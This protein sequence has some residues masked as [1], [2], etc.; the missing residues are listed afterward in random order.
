MTT[1]RRGQ[2]PALVAS[3]VVLVV[4]GAAL[5]GPWHVRSHPFNG[6]F[7]GALDLPSLPAQQPLPTQTQAPAASGHDPFLS[8]YVVIGAIVGTIL[9]VLVTRWLARVIRDHRPQVGADEA[10]AGTETGVDRMATLPALAEG[11]Q[12][13]RLALGQDVPPGDAV[14]AAWVALE[15]AAQR[16]GVSRDPAQTPTEFTV[17]VLDETRADPAATRSLLELYLRARF[18]E[19][20]LTA[21]D[22]TAAGAYLETLSAGVG[23]RRRG[24]EP[25]AGA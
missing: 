19:H 25:G 10:D 14:V 23:H 2:T 12:D 6:L 21:A 13:A 15:R 24:D 9:L 5:A 18:S 7:S 20:P 22:V 16:T 3:L 1:S 17:A 11:V 4:L 8:M